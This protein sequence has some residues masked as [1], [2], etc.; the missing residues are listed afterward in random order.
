MSRRRAAGGEPALDVAP[1]SDVGFQ[2]GLTGLFQPAGAVGAAE[3]EQAETG[4]HRLLA[5]LRRRQDALEQ[6]GRR[7]ADRGELG[8]QVFRV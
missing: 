3:P 2:G 5:V 7:R 4:S 1:G 6:Q 8:L